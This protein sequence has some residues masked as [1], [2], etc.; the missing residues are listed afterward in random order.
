M[1]TCSGVGPTGLTLEISIASDLDAVR[2]GL[3]EMLAAEA[4]VLRE[5]APQIGMDDFGDT[6]MRLVVR[7]WCAPEDW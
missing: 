1:A 3:L 4:R 6:S 7:P 5:P 2:R